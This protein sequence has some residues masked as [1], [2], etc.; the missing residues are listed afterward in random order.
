MRR[1]Q[2]HHDAADALDQCDV[3]RTTFGAEL[4][5]LRERYGPFFPFCG[6]VRRDRFVEAPGRDPFDELC[7]YPL[8]E[9]AEQHAAVTALGL[10]RVVIGSHGFDRSDAMPRGF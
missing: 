4:D 6:H 1:V 8:T 7:V 10:P 5:E 2:R 9:C 3:Y